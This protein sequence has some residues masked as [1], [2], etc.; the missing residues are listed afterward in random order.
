MK[1]KWINTAL[2]F[3]AGAFVA[4]GT[5]AGQ[6]GVSDTEIILGT[7][8][9]LS[10]PVA[11][12]MPPLKAGIEMRIDEQNE[13]GGIHGRKIVLKIEDNGYQPKQAVRAVQKLITKDEVF[14]I[15]SSFGTG[16]SAAGYA[17]AAKAG[18][19]HVFPWSGVPAIFHG[20]GDPGSFTYVA[21]YGWATSAGLDWFLRNKGAK[22]VGVLYQDDAFGKLV[23]AGVEKTLGEHGLKIIETAGYKPGDVDF[24]AQATK[25]KAAD[26]DLVVMAT[27]LRET[28]GGYV[29]IRKMGWD[30]NVLTTI[31]GRSQIIPLLAKGAV[32]GLYGIGQWNIPGTGQDSEEGVAWAAKFKEK[33]PNLPNETAAVGYLTTDWILQSLEAAGKDLTT[34]SFIN[35]MSESSYTDIFGNPTLRFKDG[36]ISPQVASVWQVEGTS[37]K[38]ISEDVVE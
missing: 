31:P 38:K 27:V 37:W 34:E 28:I 29:T 21:D 7:H 14:A 23:L 17:I 16:T 26:V 36:H 18:V 19:P 1:R 13:A 24:S 12:A 6:R 15:F 35:A 11:A 33:Y 30:V 2:A 9:D 3:V 4:G 5:L 22:K 32:D 8:I 20:K 25:L 10:G